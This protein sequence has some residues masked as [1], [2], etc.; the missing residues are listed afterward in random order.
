ME[1]GG[2]GEGRRWRGEEIER[3]GEASSLS[4]PSHE[5]FCSRLKTISAEGKEETRSSLPAVDCVA[6]VDIRRGN[7]NG[8]I[9]C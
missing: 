2:D 3:G 7:Y 8:Q 9:F 1:R 6:H 4:S 5:R